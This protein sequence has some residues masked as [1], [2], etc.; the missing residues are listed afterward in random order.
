METFD[1]HAILT[2]W[3]GRLTSTTALSPMRHLADTLMGA[4]LTELHLAD[5]YVFAE[6]TKRLSVAKKGLPTEWPTETGAFI[7]WAKKVA[8]T[9]SVTIG[10]GEVDS[11]LLT[12]AFDASISRVGSR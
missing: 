5:E 2:L 3:T 1:G 11:R 4:S 10:P 6:L 8:P 7:A 12:A 9:L